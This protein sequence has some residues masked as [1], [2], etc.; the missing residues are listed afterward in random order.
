[1]TGDLHPKTPMVTKELKGPGVS[2]YDTYLSSGFRFLIEVAAWVGGPWA[3]TKIVGHWWASIPTALVL[4]LLPALFNTPGDKKTTGI[5]TPGPLRI[6]VEAILLGAA[7]YG[8]WTVWPPW[9][10]I[11]VSVAGALMVVFGIPRYRWLLKGAPLDAD[12]P[13]PKDA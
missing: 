7:I 2:P 11:A 10:A 3:A 6:G 4:F 9:L 12:G 13:T 8:A 1:M 5:P